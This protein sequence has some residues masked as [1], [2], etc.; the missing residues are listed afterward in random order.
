[1]NL[2][3]LNLTNEYSSLSPTS[4]CGGNLNQNFLNN[5]LLLNKNQSKDAALYMRI[6]RKNNNLA[7]PGVDNISSSGGNKKLNLIDPLNLVGC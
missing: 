7:S 6:F 1:M 2:S 5:S 4:H 3:N